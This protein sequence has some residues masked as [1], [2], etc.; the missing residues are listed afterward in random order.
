[1]PAQRFGERQPN[2]P[3][4]GWTPRLFLHSSEGIDTVALGQPAAFPQI[5]HPFLFRNLNS[6]RCHGRGPPLSSDQQAVGCSFL[7]EVDL[8]Y[9]EISHP[10]PASRREKLFDVPRLSRRRTSPS[11]PC[12]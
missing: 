6:V 7:V 10:F 1:M 2:L 8:K 4:W 12:A 5:A 11:A 9:A 3:A